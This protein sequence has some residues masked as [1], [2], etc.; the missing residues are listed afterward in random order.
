M[1]N[2][3]DP[4]TVRVIAANLRRL[5]R[6]RAKPF[7]QQSLAKEAHVQQSAI[8]RILNAHNEPSICILLRICKALKC[9]LLQLLD[10]ETAEILETA[11]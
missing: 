4:H 6:D 8:C 3:R 11:S 5:M 2:L 9:N 1:Q 10:E 7:T